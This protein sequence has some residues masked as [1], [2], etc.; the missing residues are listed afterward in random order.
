MLRSSV[1]NDSPL[2]VELLDVPDKLVRFSRSAV[3][4]VTPV[5]DRNAL[6]AIEVMGWL[7]R[8]SDVSRVRPLKARVGSDVIRCWLRSS[9][10]SKDMPENAFVASEVMS[11]PPM[12]MEVRLER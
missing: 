4:W 7:F 10:V 3:S 11:E 8:F 6:A 1:V 9:E 12:V 5:S 2:N